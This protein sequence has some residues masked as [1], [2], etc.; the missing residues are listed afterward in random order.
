MLLALRGLEKIYEGKIRRTIA[1]DKVDLDVEK[2]DFLSIIGRS[3]SGKSTMMNML[4]GI[5]HPTGGKVVFDGIDLWNLN[6]TSLS[7]IRSGRMGYVPQGYSLLPHLTVLDNVL[8]PYFFFFGKGNVTGRA[9]E[10]LEQ[11][12]IFKPSGRYPAELSGGEASRVAIARALINSPSLLV[13]DEP[14]GDLDK[15]TTREIMT[16][17]QQINRQGTT[18]IMVT[19]EPDAVD[20]GNRILKMEGGRIAELR[21]A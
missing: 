17:F 11:V 6:D 18:I 12:G 10:L 1:V 4:V 8:L 16:L 9:M 3:G 15:D 2:G 7:K 13:A 19:H 21:K 5:L 20:Y 14:T